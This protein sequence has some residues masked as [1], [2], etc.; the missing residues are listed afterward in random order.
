MKEIDPQQ[1]F[2]NPVW[3]EETIDRG[4]PLSFRYVELPLEELLTI[5]E[6]SKSLYPGLRFNLRKQ[7]GH[8]RY[9]LTLLPTKDVEKDFGEV[10]GQP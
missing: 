9:I 2:Y 10:K 5:D 3:W 7:R 8:G 1:R 6:L 4:I